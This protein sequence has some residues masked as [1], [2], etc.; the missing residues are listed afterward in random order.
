M[1]YCGGTSG[2]FVVGLFIIDL[3]ICIFYEAPVDARQRG[4]LAFASDD[5]LPHE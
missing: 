2:V 3:Q 5:P 1:W 4:F